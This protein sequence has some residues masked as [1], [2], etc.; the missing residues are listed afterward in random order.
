MNRGDCLKNYNVAIEPKT[1]NYGDD[2]IWVRLTPLEVCALQE[3]CSLVLGQVWDAEQIIKYFRRKWQEN[4]LLQM[5]F[6][7]LN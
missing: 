6:F 7:K 1:N 3:A 2:G 4:G 5:A